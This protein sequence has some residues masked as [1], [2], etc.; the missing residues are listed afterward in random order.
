MHLQASL[1]GIPERVLLGKRITHIGACLYASDCARGVLCLAF[2]YGAN[3][4]TF[5][6]ASCCVA[7]S[8]E[9]VGALI[10]VSVMGVPGGGCYMRETLP[11]GGG[12]YIDQGLQHVL[13]G[14]NVPHRYRGMRGGDVRCV[15]IAFGSVNSSGSLEFIVDY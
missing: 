14:M 8:V 10:A 7:E 6:H 1:K 12:Q 4:V 13:P 11:R 5:M 3:S 2:Q 15:F 9:G